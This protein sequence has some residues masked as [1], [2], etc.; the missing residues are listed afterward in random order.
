M[1]DLSKKDDC[2]TE[3]GSPGEKFDKEIKLEATQYRA[4]LSRSSK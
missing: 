1:I 4:S 3:I 2:V